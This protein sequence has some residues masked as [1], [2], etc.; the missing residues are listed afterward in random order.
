MII[1][2]VIIIVIILLGIIT[3]IIAIAIA[4]TI[5]I[6]TA[7]GHEEVLRPAHRHGRGPGHLRRSEKG[8]VSGYCAIVLI[9]IRGNTTIYTKYIISQTII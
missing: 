3:I 4:V 1:F 5:A 9:L 6:A 8:E 7:R 2:I